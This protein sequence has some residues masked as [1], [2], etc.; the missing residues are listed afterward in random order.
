MLV[1]THLIGWVLSPIATVIT[2]WVLIKKVTGASLKY[3][4]Q[5][6]IAWV[7]IAVL[8]DYF[9]LVKLLK[10]ADGY[11][12]LDVYLYYA[13]MFILPVVVGWYKTRKKADVVTIESH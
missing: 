4:I 5:I 6:A 3:Y 11:Y 1:P 7:F 10:P 9:F 8:F 13:L 12:K 2:L